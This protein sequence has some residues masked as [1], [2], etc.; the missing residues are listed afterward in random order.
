[1]FDC[2]IHSN[3]SADSTLDAS[4]A[5]ETA[6]KLGLDGIAFTDHLDFDY[7][8]ETF[9]IDF[10]QYISDI[11]LIR[12]KYDKRLKVLKAM[13]VGIQPHVLEDSL[14][15]VN[16][17]DFDYVLASVHIID[18]IDPYRNK[19]YY[20]KDKIEAYGR[21]LEKI[22]FMVKN[23]KSFDMVGHFDYIIRFASYADRTLRYADHHEILDT[24]MKELILQGR[25]FELNTRAYTDSPADAEYDIELLKRYRQLG[26][27]LI[28]LGSDAHRTGHIA[29]RFKYFAQMIRDAGFS[30]TVH[31]EE[32][33]PVFDKL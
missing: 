30:Y 9:L 33:K 2:H 23:F 4:C 15:V 31:F 13:E 28:C 16:S 22:L 29:G 27:E 6:I 14:N 18:G 8:G 25:G 5:C 7:P 19:K 21:Y 10:A 3:F 20:G 1:M 12:S 17:Y 32:R 11:S 26:G 24:I